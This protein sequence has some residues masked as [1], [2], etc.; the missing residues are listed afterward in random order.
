MLIIDFLV[1][2]YGDF[3]VGIFGVG[4]VDMILFVY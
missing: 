3:M 1:V 4:W 2:G